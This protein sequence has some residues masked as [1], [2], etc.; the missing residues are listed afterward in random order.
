MKKKTSSTG[1]KNSCQIGKVTLKDRRTRTES[2]KRWLLRQLNDPYVQKAKQQGYRSRAAFKLH[3]IDQKFNL[4]KP[5]ITVIDLGASPGGWTQVAIEKVHSKNQKGTVIGIDLQEMKPL[6]GALF[7]QG[8]FLDEETYQSLLQLIPSQADLVLS[9]MAASACGMSDIDHI[10]IMALLEM[11]YEFCLI[12]LKP[13]G[14]MVAKVLR[15]GTESNLLQKLKK[16]FAKV[17]HFKPLSSRQDSSEMY[18]VGLGFR[19]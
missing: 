14:A 2:S 4:L 16:N 7:L 12:T 9:D 19:K 5:G 3:E 18:V 1:G 10:R 6:E 15:G 8:D 13:G 11:V 17:V